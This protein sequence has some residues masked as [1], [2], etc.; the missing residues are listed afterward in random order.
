[1]PRERLPKG[2]ALGVPEPD[3]VIFAAAR[4]RSPI[5]RQGQRVYGLVVPGERSPQLARCHVPQFDLGSTRG[6]QRLPIRK[7]NPAPHHA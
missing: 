3:P 7:E 2:P 6:G 5:G 1:M 4:E